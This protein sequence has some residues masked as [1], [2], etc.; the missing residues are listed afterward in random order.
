MKL[1][2]TGF[3]SSWIKIRRSLSPCCP[4]VHET[5]D[6]RPT[7]MVRDMRGMRGKSRGRWMSASVGDQRRWG[8]FSPEGSAGDCAHGHELLQGGIHALAGYAVAAS[9]GQG[10]V[11]GIAGEPALRPILAKILHG[12]LGEDTRQGAACAPGR[13]GIGM[14]F[15]QAAAGSRLRRRVGRLE[16]G[17]D[18]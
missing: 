16:D 10:G 11:L 4:R 7:E 1:P 8:R 3:R 14:P 15:W 12:V 17:H 13:G 2:T 18:N 5:R 6:F 9:V